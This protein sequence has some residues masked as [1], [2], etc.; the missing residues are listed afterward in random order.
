MG[1]DYDKLHASL[2]STL[3]TLES[4]DEIEPDMLEYMCNI[5]IDLEQSTLSLDE[6]A[7]TITPFLESSGYEDEAIEQ[8]CSKVGDLLI[9]SGD[10]AGGDNGQSSSSL[11][12]LH[13]EVSMQDELLKSAADEDLVNALDGKKKAQANANTQREAFGNVE[14]SKDKRKQ[15][16]E[17]EKARKE[18]EANL[19]AMEEEEENLA[20]Q[21]KVAEMIL[22]DY[23]SGRNEKDIQCLN[24]SISLDNGRCLLE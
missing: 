16:Q 22:P 11:K 4:D 23:S 14:S 8:V 9:G 6:V 7:E 13:K 21:G 10:D 2:K 1:V 19:L 24:V 17:L 12:V 15:K 20:K 18:Y 3:Q 5:L